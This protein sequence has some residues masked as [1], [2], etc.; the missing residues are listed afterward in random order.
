MLDTSREPAA[1]EKHGDM[2][3]FE[4][5]Q[6]M[7]RDVANHEYLEYGKHEGFLYGTK[8][9]TVRDIMRMRK[10]PILDIETPVI[11]A[12]TFLTSKEQSFLKILIF[13]EFL[14]ILKY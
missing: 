5:E 12:V 8:L 10:I 1:N 7:L 9:S 14:E 6:T 3:H 13:C 4:T 11:T 2:W